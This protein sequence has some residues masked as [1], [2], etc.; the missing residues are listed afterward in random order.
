MIIQMTVG[1]QTVRRLAQFVMEKGV[2]Q[3]HLLEVDP[4]SPQAWRDL[5]GRFVAGSS[6]RGPFYLFFS[7]QTSTSPAALTRVP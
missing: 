6:K 3:L 5:Q 1:D 4:L 2:S 7:A